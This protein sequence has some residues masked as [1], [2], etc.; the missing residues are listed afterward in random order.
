MAQMK[1]AV[2]TLMAKK[3]RVEKADAE[4]NRLKGKQQAIMDDLKS[5]FDVS[6]TAA[7]DKKLAAITKTTDADE[8]AFKNGVEK[9]EVDYVWD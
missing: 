2:Q 1:E 3:S 9:L 6:T 8:A 7:A 5:R 4:T